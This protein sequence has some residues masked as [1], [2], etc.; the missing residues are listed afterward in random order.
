MLREL[1][2]DVSIGE[3][4]CVYSTVHT[5]NDNDGFTTF[6]GQKANTLVR[7]YSCTITFLL[8]FSPVA[9][10]PRACSAVL[11]LGAG[12]MQGRAARAD[13]SQVCRLQRM[14]CLAF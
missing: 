5:H 11:L 3:Q 1:A 13:C 8:N 4:N 10:S 14:R 6:V 9:G 7:M 2:C 12:R